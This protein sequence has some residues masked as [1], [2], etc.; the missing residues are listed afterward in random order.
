MKSLFFKF[1]RVVRAG[2]M[3]SGW[4]IPSLGTGLNIIHGRNAS[5][6]TTTAKALIAALWPESEDR[7]LDLLSG[8]GKGGVDWK[9]TCEGRRAVLCERDG[10]S[11]NGD[12]RDF[13][14]Y[15]TFGSRCFIALHDLF[16]RS[17]ED[18]REIAK[19][20]RRE[21]AGG[22]DLDEASEKCGFLPKGKLKW[23]HNE[24]N[25]YKRLD[26]EVSV[27]RRHNN[28]LLHEEGKLPDLIEKLQSARASRDR[29]DVLKRAIEYREILDQH[30]ADQGTLNNFPPVL[31]NLQGNELEELR[32]HRKRQRVIAVENNRIAEEIGEIDQ[33]IQLLGLPAEGLPPTLLDELQNRC[34]ELRD[35]TQRLD[36]KRTE[37]NQALTDRTQSLA[38][39]GEGLDPEQI[40]LGL[41]DLNRVATLVDQ[42]SG[43]DQDRSELESRIRSL[44]GLPDGAERGIELR[45]LRDAVGSITRWM[46][47]AS[48]G[49]PS[50]PSWLSWLFILMAVLLATSALF[51]N[52]TDS[53]AFWCAMIFSAVTAGVAV[54]SLFGR[55]TKPEDFPPRTPPPDWENTVSVSRRFQELVEKLQ[56]AELDELRFQESENLK[57]E[58]DF[59]T[60]E[61]EQSRLELDKLELGFAINPVLFKELV[62][63]ASNW[64][65]ACHRVA[66]AEASINQIMGDLQSALLVAQTLIAPYGYGNNLTGSA[67]LEAVKDDLARKQNTLDKKNQEKRNKIRDAAEI[68]REMQANLPEQ[69]Q[70]LG[71]AG[72]NAGPNDEDDLQRLLEQLPQYTQAREAVVGNQRRVQDAGSFFAKNAE[73]N[74][75]DLQ[76]LTAELSKTETVAEAYE[77]L[78]EEKTLLDDAIKAA[79]Q[80]TDIEEKLEAR[81][82]AKA[83]LLQSRRDKLE[84]FAGGLLVSHLVRSMGASAMPDVFNRA[85]GFFSAFTNGEW[86]ITPPDKEEEFRARRTDGSLSQPLQELSG[87]TRAQLILAA[88]MGFISAGE[89]ETLFPLILDETL[90]NSDDQRAGQIIDALISLAKD[91]RQIIYFTAQQDEVDKWRQRGG[92]DVTIIDLDALRGTGRAVQPFERVDRALPRL[93]PQAVEDYDAYG[94][95]LEVPAFDPRNSMETFHLWHLCEE[96]ESL[97]RLLKLGFETWGPLRSALSH[98]QEIEGMDTGRIKAAAAVLEKVS[99]CWRRGRGKPLAKE[100]LKDGGVSDTFLDRVWERS[101]EEEFDARRLIQGLQDNPIPRFREETLQKLKDYLVAKEIFADEEPMTFQQIRMEVDP[102]ARQHGLDPERI[103]YLLGKIAG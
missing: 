93:I 85:A 39:L 42:W 33:E 54:F 48:G 103:D 51:L 29:K 32:R 47:R 89:G 79:K 90:A 55:K 96:S 43:L 22:F 91:G 2:G 31:A 50:L 34:N 84:S 82:V 16:G 59:K 64:R 6:K 99:E 70:L 27:L 17:D 63:N 24:R 38:A 81:E 68:A 66:Q 98:G 8:Y 87:G 74:D 83:E 60:T 69:N 95:I 56:K 101:R 75:L 52:H 78:L 94:K 15:D 71:R 49:R 12:A 77:G 58:L 102:I 14:P 19:K 45:E 26:H 97:H 40:H 1:I 88:R 46:N 23:G 4:T 7:K 10:V 57:R 80:K 18:S 9:V 65:E 28:Q 62:H 13:P 73:W 30:A 86:E 76:D 20:I 37:K 5:G 92:S 41:Q 72:L 67:S 44:V 61:L 21:A 3:P 11:W 25:D 53:I 36:A 35:L 100:D